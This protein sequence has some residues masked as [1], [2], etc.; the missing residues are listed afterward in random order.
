MCKS[1]STWL[2]L[3]LKVW[4]PGGCSA[5]P[6]VRGPVCPKLPEISVADRIL[7][8]LSTCSLARVQGS[9]D[10]LPAHDWVFMVAWAVSSPGDEGWDVHGGLGCMLLWG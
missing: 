5:F 9:K 4:A 3:Y 6:G 10:T 1:E 7:S 8:F 2:L